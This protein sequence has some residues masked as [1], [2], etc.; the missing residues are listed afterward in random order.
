MQLPTNWHL[1]YVDADGDSITMVTDADVTRAAEARAADTS[2]G[3]LMFKLLVSGK[4]RAMAA[5][6]VPPPPP[7]II[8]VSADGAPEPR[9]LPGRPRETDALKA[10]RKRQN[11]IDSVPAGQRTLF[12]SSLR[13]V[14]GQATLG[15]PM[16][17]VRTPTTV[18]PPVADGSMFSMGPGAGT[19]V[20]PPRTAGTPPPDNA[21]T[22]G[23]TD[24]TVSATRQ[25]QAARRSSARAA[26]GAVR[27]E[28]HCAADAKTLLDGAVVS[29]LDDMDAKEP[30]LKQQ[31]TW[32]HKEL[33]LKIYNACPSLEDARDVLRALGSP[34]LTLSKS[35]LW[36]W[37]NGGTVSKPRGPK[38]T[39]A[40]F[41]FDVRDRLLFKEGAAASIHPKLLD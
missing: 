38:P 23:A 3:T 21:S 25:R 10:E 6:R 9:R 20:L 28:K 14:S 5:D 12:A 2:T 17:A 1:S 31:Y 39:P 40:E 34:F 26:A 8:A 37:M 11:L 29:V 27:F 22:P 19:P 30:R 7:K 13:G 24:D 16:L 32:W 36:R 18:T 35:S 15:S 4:R 41:L 33:A